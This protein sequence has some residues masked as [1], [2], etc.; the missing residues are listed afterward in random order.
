MTSRALEVVRPAA[1]GSAAAR[2]RGAPRGC[3][4]SAGARGARGARAPRL[5]RTAVGSAPSTRALAAAFDLYMLAHALRPAVKAA[6]VRD[7]RAVYA[8]ALAFEAA[9]A[10]LAA[11]PAHPP[12]SSDATAASGRGK[13]A[14]VWRVRP[15]KSLAECAWRNMLVD[16]ALADALRVEAGLALAGSVRPLPRRRC[17]AY[18]AAVPTLL[19]AVVLPLLAVVEVAG[20][21]CDIR[22]LCAR[23]A[24]LSGAAF[25]AVRQLRTLETGRGESGGDGKRARQSP[26]ATCA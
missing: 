7:R 2:V 16:L 8:P 21:W 9:E 17:T 14:A 10:A 24:L 19:N 15:G 13:V 25:T 18:V 26:D 6:A 20:V 4:G 11:P 3:G 5:P 1:S 22:W 12:N 23:V